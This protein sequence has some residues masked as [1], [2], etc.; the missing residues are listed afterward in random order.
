MDG[1][2]AGKEETTFF[3][4]G[5][6]LMR[7]GACW[8]GSNITAGEAARFREKEFSLRYGLWTVTRLLKLP[9]SGG[10]KA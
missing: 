10:W 8:T 9:Y 4:K 1:R 3:F 5:D 2:Y 6:D 7:L